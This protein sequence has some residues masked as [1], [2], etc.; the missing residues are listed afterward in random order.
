[1]NQK[2]IKSLRNGAGMFLNLKKI[3]KSFSCAL[4]G[5][6][7]LI[8]REHNFRIGFVISVFVVVYAIFL[9][10]P[11]SKIVWIIILSGFVLTAEALN[12]AAERLADQINDTADKEKTAGII[13]DIAAAGVVLAVI[14]AFV[15]SFYIFGTYYALLL[16]G[17][18]TTILIFLYL[19]SFI[20]RK[21]V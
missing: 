3:L 2:E 4:S 14:V 20:F 10:L 9:R 18:G 11:W 1:M 13:K 8:C 21:Q 12:S 7:Y 17:L 15:V 16:V 5:M 19:L 6:L